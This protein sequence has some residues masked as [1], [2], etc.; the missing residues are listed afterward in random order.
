MDESE[1]CLLVQGEWY[2]FN[3]DYLE[4]LKNSL[5]EIPVFYDSRFDLN[6]SQLDKFQEQ[7]AEE[8][9]DRD[10]YKGK[11]FEAIKKAMKTKYYAERAFNLM[12]VS[13]GF[14]LGDRQNIKIGESTIEVADLYREE[15]IFSV[16]R[17][18]SSADFSYVT[19]QSSIAINAYKSGTIPRAGKI[20]KIV[21]WLIFNRSQQLTLHNNRLEWDELNMLILK[22]RLDQWKKEVRLAGFQPEIWI[23][24]QTKD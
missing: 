10:E 17:G 5:S 2:E 19:D 8:E 16:K 21:I 22:N 6:Q 12:R 4:Y 24:Y 23:N 15:T 20:K 11:D 9:K 18:N 14:I 7:K 1:R 13:D 3:D